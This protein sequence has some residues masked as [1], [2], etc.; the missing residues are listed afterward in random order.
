MESP[1]W[2]RMASQS[3][4]LLDAALEVWLVSSMVLSNS[5]QL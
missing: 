1:Y 2:C 4:F 5:A 3:G